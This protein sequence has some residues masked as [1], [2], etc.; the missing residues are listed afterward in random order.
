MDTRLVQPPAPPLGHRDDQPHRIRTSP[1]P[2][3][4]KANSPRI[5]G[6]SPANGGEGEAHLVLCFAGLTRL[7]PQE[8]Q[9][10]PGRALLRVCDAGRVQHPWRVAQN[11]SVPGWALTQ[12]AGARGG[13]PED[14]GSRG[15][16]R[17][18]WIGL[19][20]GLLA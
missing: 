4:S 15:V 19:P 16:L 9:K 10:T 12:I 20:H 5:G 6:S 8:G 7:A 2:P 3:T 18:G 13:Y 14:S 11:K 17:L 1:H